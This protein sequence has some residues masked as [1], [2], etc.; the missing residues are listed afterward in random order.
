MSSYQH[1]YI[2]KLYFFSSSINVNACRPFCVEVRL[3]SFG[4]LP[5]YDI[6]VQNRHLS[7][8]NSPHPQKQQQQSPTGLESTLVMLPNI[9]TTYT[10]LTTAGECWKRITVL[11]TVYVFNSRFFKLD[12]DA[13]TENSVREQTLKRTEPDVVSS[14]N[15]GS[16]VTCCVTHSEESTTRLLAR[17]AFALVFYCLSSKTSN[18]AE[19]LCGIG[20]MEFGNHKALILLCGEAIRPALYWKMIWP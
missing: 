5:K 2:T 6:L 7:L 9:L 17:F 10:I 1:H 19:T 16:M 13:I 4:H 14:T 3:D 15:I 8:P 18:F 20:D 12:I 11:G